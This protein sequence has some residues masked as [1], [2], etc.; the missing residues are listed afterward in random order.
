[1]T[2][3]QELGGG[4][5]VAS[6]LSS[7]VKDEY[8]ATFATAFD[9]DRHWIGLNDAGSEGNWAWTKGES[10]AW[11]NWKS[12]E[13]DNN[14]GEDCVSAK[15]SNGEWEV[16][17][18]GS[19]TINAVLCMKGTS[20]SVGQAPA[21]TPAPTST[22]TKDKKYSYSYCGIAWYEN[23]A[24][25]SRSSCCQECQDDSHN[26]YTLDKI[27]YKA[28]DCYCIDTTRQGASLSLV[29]IPRN[30]VL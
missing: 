12:D 6:V 15:K 25:Y 1:M 29:K 3:C 17:N 8:L 2:R 14:S 9:E 5:K 16:Q 26:P 24:Q 21:P 22:E 18:C 7:E 13:P 20:S 30:A 23:Q 28:G 27:S 4:A 11:Q 19:S 10:Y